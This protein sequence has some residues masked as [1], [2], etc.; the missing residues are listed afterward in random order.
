M[1]KERDLTKGN[2]TSVIVKFAIPMMI[3]NIFQQIYL[4]VDSAIVGKLVGK[5]ALAATGSAFPVLFLISSLV[6][7]FSIGG[8]VLISQNYGAKKIDKVKSA[9]ETLHIMMIVAA[10]VFGALGILTS[11]TIFR[12]LNFPEDRLSLIT[13]Y[14]NIL[15]FGN[16]GIFG[17]NALAASLRGL[18]DSKTPVYFLIISNLINIAG[19]L[20]FVAVFKWG[21]NGAAISTVISYFIAYLAAIVYLNKKHKIL[22]TSFKIKIDKESLRKILKLGL[23]SSGQMFVVSLGNII[24]FSFVNLFGINVVA[25]YTAA[26]RI[27]SFATMPSMF[28]ANALT[29][30]VGQNYGAKKMDRVK[31]GFKSTLIINASISVTI[32]AIALFFSHPLLSIFT[33]DEQV[34][35]IGIRYFKIVSPFY[36][37]FGMMFSFSGLYRGLGDTILPFYITL[38]ALWIVRL[39]S[40]VFMAMH[41]TWHPLH[42]VPIDYYGLWWSE[43]L[44][45]FTGFSLSFLYYISKK[46]Y[47]KAMV[48]E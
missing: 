32:T 22:K 40:G 29:A 25:G 46:W 36:I 44:G 26:I 2:E 9:S 34:I 10:F 38:V 13:S 11:K 3:G 8:T 1:K 17:Y 37:I 21:L 48:N 4:L 5:D 23:P 30:F 14:F 41:I 43:P 47:K 7:G 20:L 19:D 24:F 45:W 28:F 18:G 42:L 35:S 39:P 12:L 16:I 15:M 31:R 6:I 27:N 33:N